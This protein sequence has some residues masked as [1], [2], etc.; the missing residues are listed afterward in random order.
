MSLESEHFMNG[1]KAVWELTI[2]FILDAFKSTFVLI[3]PL[4]HWCEW[5][6]LRQLL[7]HKNLMVGMRDVVPART[8]P[9]LHP[10]SPPTVL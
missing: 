3:K 6:D 8:S 4:N 7:L 2:M 5:V 10:P 1:S 9:P